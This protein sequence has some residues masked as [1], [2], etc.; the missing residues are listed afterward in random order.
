MY[1]FTVEESNFLSIYAGKTR[2]E[3]I[4][5]LGDVLVNE[6][7][8][9]MVALI[10]QVVTKLDGITDQVFEQCEFIPAESEE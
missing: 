2:L 6:K 7:D 10:M 9:D 8:D 5:V 4:R 1:R 3:T